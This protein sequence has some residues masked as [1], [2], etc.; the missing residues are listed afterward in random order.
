[1]IGARVGVGLGGMMDDH[2]STECAADVGGA[3]GVGNRLGVM[4]VGEIVGEGGWLCE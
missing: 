2:G 4:G 1:M 3:E